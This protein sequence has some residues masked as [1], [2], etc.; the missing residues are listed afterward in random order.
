MVICWI[1]ASVEKKKKNTFKTINKVQCEKS[2]LNS[3]V[4]YSQYSFKA[5]VSQFFALGYIHACVYKVIRVCLQGHV[6]D[7]FFFIRRREHKPHLKTGYMGSRHTQEQ[8]TSFVAGRQQPRKSETY[9][10]VAMSFLHCVCV[11]QIKPKTGNSL[12]FSAADDDATT[13]AVFDEIYWISSSIS[14]SRQRRR[15]PHR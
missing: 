11:A 9:R 7:F 5:R 14:R 12:T 3:K 6:D 15:D 8:P 2:M 4:S 1:A 10:A 13:I